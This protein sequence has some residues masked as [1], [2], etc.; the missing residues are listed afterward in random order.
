MQGR[1]GERR[2][3]AGTWL[4]SRDGR[5]AASGVHMAAGWGQPASC[6]G[7]ARG[8]RLG[9]VGEMRPACVGSA[10]GR[11]GGRQ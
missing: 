7:R 11:G 5:R 8:R 1:V 6:A 4:R 2:R 3:P 10:S 9:T